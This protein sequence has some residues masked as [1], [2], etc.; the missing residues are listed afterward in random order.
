MVNEFKA[1]D[2]AL[3]DESEFAKDLF[4]RPSLAVDDRISFSNI[5]EFSAFTYED[6]LF[7]NKFTSAIVVDDGRSFSNISD[8][9]DNLISDTTFTTAFKVDDRRSFSNKS[10]LSESIFDHL[11]SGIASTITYEVDDVRSF[12]NISNLSENISDNSETTS[13]SNTTNFDN[14][15]SDTMITATRKKQEDHIIQ[16]SNATVDKQVSSMVTFLD[17][18]RQK[19]FNVESSPT[20]VR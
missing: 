1:C 13:F 6:L 11:I 7:D 4:V 12:S 8:L 5:S 10:N 15:T 17:T 9:C 3:D 16:S 20:K 18:T 2:H 19:A 14:V